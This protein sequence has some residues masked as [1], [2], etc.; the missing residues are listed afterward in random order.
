MSV[1]PGAREGS[2]KRPS[3]DPAVPVGENPE[4]SPAKWVSPNEGDTESSLALCTWPNR[5]R[6]G[7]EWHGQRRTCC[8]WDP[9]PG[10]HWRSP[11]GSQ[12]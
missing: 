7:V 2:R 11:C 8:L 10:G 6:A 9:P 1:A 3:P 12:L 4:G 5:V